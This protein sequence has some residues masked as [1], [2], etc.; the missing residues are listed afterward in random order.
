MVRSL[1]FSLQ[2]SNNGKLAQLD[3]L[4]KEYKN[5]VNYFLKRLF[6]KKELSEDFLKLYQ[7]SLSYAYK[8]CAKRQALKIFKIWCRSKKKKRKP[9]LRNISLMLDRRFVKLQKG[10]NSFDYWLKVSTL[11]KGNPILVPVKNYNYAQKYFTGWNLRPGARLLK[12]DGKWLVQLTFE[13]ET[14]E[15]KKAGKIIGID[16]GIK[17]LITTSEKEFLGK[18]IEKLIQKIQRKRQG[19]KAFKRALKERDYYI[20]Q[21]VKQLNWFQLKKIVIENIKNVKKNTNK[22]RKL[23]HEF[24]SKFHWWTYSRLLRRIQEL[25]EISG[26]HCQL[27][28]PAYTSQT[29]SQ[30][31]YVHRLNRT[32]E[33]FKCRNCGYTEDADFVASLNIL[34]LGLAQEP[35]VPGR[36]KAL[37]GATMKTQHLSAEFSYTRYYGELE[38]A[39]TM[40]KSHIYTFDIEVYDPKVDDDWRQAKF[41]VHGIDD[42]LWTDDVDAVVAFIRES[43][44]RANHAVARQI[45]R[46]AVKEAYDDTEEGATEFAVGL[47]EKLK[48]AGIL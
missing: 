7:S 48:D 31:G 24:R 36:E 30:C 38:E 1:K 9:K 11:N 32:G 46:E 22:E 28:N 43:C 15:K 29:C 3:A 6:Q 39:N 34:N 5:T 37:T 18:D 25:A 45:I 2:F 33:I 47:V 14:P 44:L 42:V 4:S 12:K 20:N 8:Q 26:V 16:I 27:V 10:Q 23:G 13:K 21:T 41:L 35:M 17:K 19:S 40:S